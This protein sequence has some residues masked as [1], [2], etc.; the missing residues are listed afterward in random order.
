LEVFIVEFSYIELYVDLL[1]CT[2]V[3][4]SRELKQMTSNMSHS[5]V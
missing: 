2:S 3:A 4:K 5:G 1:L